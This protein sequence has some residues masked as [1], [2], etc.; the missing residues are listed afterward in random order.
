MK[1]T[2]PEMTD[3]LQKVGCAYSEEFVYD[4]KDDAVWA[5][6]LR[7]FEYFSSDTLAIEIHLDDFEVEA[8]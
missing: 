7:V 2:G 5:K 8:H 4:F 6:I 1:L 3:I